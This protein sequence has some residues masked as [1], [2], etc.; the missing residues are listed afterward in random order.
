MSPISREDPVVALPDESARPRFVRPRFPIAIPPLKWISARFK[1]GGAAEFRR[2]AD[3]RWWFCRVE[4]LRA[5]RRGYLLLAQHWTAVRQDSYRRLAAWLSASMGFV[6]VGTVGI[7]LLARRYV[8]QPLAELHRRLKILGHSDAM[9]RTPDGGEIECTSEEFKHKKQL[10]G[11]WRRLLQESECKLQLERR[12]LNADKLVAIAT[13]VSGFAH[14]IGTPLSVI[15]GRAEILLD[16]NFEQ[17]EL[18]ENLQVIIAQTDHVTRMVR[19]LLDLGQRRTAIRIASDVRAIVDRAIQLLE[20]EAVRGGVVVIANLGSKPLMVDCDPDQLQQ[21]F[22]NLEA[23]AIEA[24]A[25]G[26]GILR[27]DSLA[28]EPHGKVSFSFE[29]TGPGVPTAIRDRIFEPF[30]TTKGPGQG[31]GM[32]LAVS[33]SVI[34]DHDGELTLEQR[35]HGACFLVTLPASRSFELAPCTEEQHTDGTA[36]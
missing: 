29:D 35:A 19:I 18:L 8:T 15:R 27:V 22:L 11:T 5:G 14:A 23:N 26:G 25:Q 1:S 10:A 7:P 9:E 6:L 12:R 2:R 13:L 16:S 28:D 21:V 32:G 31:Y 33:Q 20:P 3:G 4:P 30:F 24:M 34:G 36:S 17:S